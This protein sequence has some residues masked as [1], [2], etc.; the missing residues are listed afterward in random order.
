MCLV[1]ETMVVR[2]MTIDIHEIPRWLAS[3]ADKSRDLNMSMARS[4][5]TDQH[6]SP[7]FYTSPSRGRR[8]PGIRPGLV[9]EA[10][11]FQREIRP[12]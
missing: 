9:L 12:G 10:G 2:L 7:Y 11:P 4:V 5:S 1:A 8:P 3:N 6:L